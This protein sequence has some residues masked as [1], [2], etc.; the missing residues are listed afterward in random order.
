MLLSAGSCGLTRIQNEAVH[1]LKEC[2]GTNIITSVRF[3]M[4]PS[5]GKLVWLALQWKFCVLL[6]AKIELE[7]RNRKKTYSCISYFDPFLIKVCIVNIFGQA[8]YTLLLCSSR[9]LS[10][11]VRMVH[12]YVRRWRTTLVLVK[13]YIILWTFCTWILHLMCVVH[14]ALGFGMPSPGRH[15]LHSWFSPSTN[16]IWYSKYF[17]RWPLKTCMEK[18]GNLE[19]EAFS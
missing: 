12:V 18:T 10:L 1:L 14:L 15:H 2:I 6:A 19:A 9:K 8:Q 11:C 13:I 4:P 16:R 7:S 3:W 5:E 17:I